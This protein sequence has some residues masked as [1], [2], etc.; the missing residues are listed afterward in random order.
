MPLNPHLFPSAS[1]RLSPPAPDR[2]R[3]SVSLPGRAVSASDGCKAINQ[4]L[5]ERDGNIKLN[6]S[7]HAHLLQLVRELLKPLCV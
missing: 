5:Q 4:K 1:P 2:P 7:V 6:K 3:T